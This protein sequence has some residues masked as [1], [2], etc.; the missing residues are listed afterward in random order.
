MPIGISMFAAVSDSNDRGRAMA[1]RQRAPDA[2]I[3]AVKS[4]LSFVTG[5]SS[6]SRRTGNERLK[7]Q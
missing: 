7:A 3:A 4:S 5:R 2:G 6:V 1:D